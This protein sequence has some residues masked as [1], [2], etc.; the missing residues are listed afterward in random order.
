[1]EPVKKQSSEASRLPE[2]AKKFLTDKVGVVVSALLVLIIGG[3]GAWVPVA[4]APQRMWL[5]LAALAVFLFAAFAFAFCWVERRMHRALVVGCVLPLGALLYFL[6]SLLPHSG[7]SPRPAADVIESI[8][9]ADVA[10]TLE[11]RDGR[12]Q[13]VVDSAVLPVEVLVEVTSRH[14][15]KLW[16]QQVSV[17]DCER[18]QGR[19]VCTLPA[20][21]YAP[22]RFMSLS[23]LDA[24][25]KA[26][27]VVA[28]TPDGECDHFAGYAIRAGI[29]LFVANKA[30]HI[31]VDRHP[32]NDDL[33]N[34]EREHVVV[35]GPYDSAQTSRILK[36]CLRLGCGPV[37]SL[38]SA[39]ALRG[40]ECGEHVPLLFRLTSNNTA[41]AQA[42]TGQLEREFA[43]DPRSNVLYI[44]YDDEEW[45]T[46]PSPFTTP[47]IRRVSCSVSSRRHCSRA[48][49]TSFCIGSGST[50]TRATA[51]ASSCSVRALLARRKPGFPTR[52]STT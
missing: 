17:K 4:T 20:L 49:R 13:F 32:D 26:R 18:E 11:H 30:T 6:S 25:I 12:V 47:S 42:M 22:E 8:M 14:G 33:A 44:V 10:L 40:L 1:M 28:Y 35:L 15:T 19:L 3:Y 39:S 16:T 7:D 52:A 48:T 41:R 2:S 29:D 34:I 51:M 38:S 21:D 50:T 31:S 27:K 37:V 9:M 36:A 5:G 24:M 43:A 46:P 45:G 23:W